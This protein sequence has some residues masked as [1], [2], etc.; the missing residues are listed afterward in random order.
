MR[1]SRLLRNDRGALSYRNIGEIGPSV[2]VEQCSIENNGYFLYGNISSSTQAME[3]KLHNTIVYTFLF[4]FD[5]FY[6]I[7][8]FLV[9]FFAR[10]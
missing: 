1:N 8:I 6:N 4:F 10:Q 5:V 2:I 9:F 3:F 7:L